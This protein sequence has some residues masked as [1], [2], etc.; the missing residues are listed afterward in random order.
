MKYIILIPA[1]ACW[2]VLARGSIR[3]AFLYVYLPSILLLPHYYVLHFPHTPPLSFGDIAILPLGVALVATEMRRWRLAWMD[4]WVFL[5]AA[6]A[7]LSEAF[8]NELATGDVAG[9]IKALSSMSYNVNNGIYQFFAGTTTILLPYMLGKLLIEGGL[10]NGQPVRKVMIRLM[11]VMLAIVSAISVFDFLSGTSSWQRTFRHLF[12]YQYVEW[13]EQVR[14]GFGRIA[15]PYGHAILAGMV[16]LTALIYCLWLYWVDHKWGRRRLVNGVPLTERGLVLIALVGGLIMTQ[17]RGPWVGVALSV[18]FALLMRMY[19]IRKAALVFMV[20]MILAGSA[21]WVIG[22]RYTAG[23]QQ[24]AGSQEQAS[25]IYRRQLL[26]SYTPVVLERPLFGWGFTDDPTPNGQ[27]SIDNQFLWLA[28]TQGFVG[29]GLFLL[30]AAASGA[31]LLKLAARPV[32]DPG[33]RALILAHMAVLLGLMVTLTTVYMGLQVVE[34]FFMVVG[35]VQGMNPANV[36][37]PQAAG[38]AGPLRF[39]RVLT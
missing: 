10:V 38:Y 28:V 13:P 21:M 8:T 27:K 6:S 22:G 1:L 4:L 36:G 33:D 34:V 29:M 31:R 14:W 23:Q 18:V 20:L 37:A 24:T 26:E 39:R 35:W 7:G 11:V 3:Q 19:N 12:P 2:M 25:A 17:S 15:G 30:I 5:F 16:F 9:M 32:V